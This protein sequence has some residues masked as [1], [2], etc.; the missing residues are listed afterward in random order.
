M[1]TQA[2]DE[3]AALISINTTTSAISFNTFTLLN[4]VEL[5]G[6]HIQYA[7][8][9][10]KRSA[11]SRSF[12]VVEQ[13]FFG[14]IGGGAMPMTVSR[15]FSERLSLVSMPSLQRLGVE[16]LASRYHLI[17]IEIQSSNL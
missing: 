10:S 2:Q 16:N 6:F 13:Q 15:H 12:V 4:E 7:W 9:C 3:K 17:Y 14:A 8:H 11:A 5:S 1:N